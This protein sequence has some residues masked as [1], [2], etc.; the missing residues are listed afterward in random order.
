MPSPKRCS[1]RYRKLGN[2][3]FVRLCIRNLIPA[4]PKKRGKPG[5]L[6]AHHGA[7]HSWARG[8]ISN[9]RR[10]NSGRLQSLILTRQ[11]PLGK[12]Q[13]FH[14]SPSGHFKGFGLCRVAKRVPFGI[15]EPYLQYVGLS[16][17]L[18]FLWSSHAMECI[19]KKLTKQAELC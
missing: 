15:R 2:G 10:C 1:M 19:Y 4:Q 6:P 11:Y 13:Q 8:L 17:G 16:L 18:F 7:A 12:G 14:A 3:Q 5:L 9:A